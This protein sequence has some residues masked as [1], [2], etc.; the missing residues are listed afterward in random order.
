[1]PSSNVGSFF[2]PNQGQGRTIR[3]ISHPWINKKMILKC[4]KMFFSLVY[5]V[6]AINFS[7]HVNNV[8][9]YVNPRSV[10]FQIKPYDILCLNLDYLLFSIAL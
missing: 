1:M 8:F 3:K 10:G 7:M 6:Y 2:R 5:I 4:C 9:H